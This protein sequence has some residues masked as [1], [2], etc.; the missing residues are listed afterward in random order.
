MYNRRKVI[1][2]LVVNPVIYND[3][4]LQDMLYNSGT[5]IRVNNNS[6]T[7]FKTHSMRWNPYLILLE[8]P[9]TQH[10]KGRGPGKNQLYYCS[11]KGTLQYNDS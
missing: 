8:L 6:L 10:W 3:D 4:L 11:A 2:N 5:N 9:R 1:T 7:G